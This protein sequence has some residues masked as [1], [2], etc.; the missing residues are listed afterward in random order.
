MA[1]TAKWVRSSAGDAVTVLKSV[2]QD[3]ALA[4]MEFLTNNFWGYRYV[5]TRLGQG[6]IH[7]RFRRGF[8]M[9]E[10]PGRSRFAQR[11]E[12]SRRD[13]DHRLERRDLDDRVGHSS[14]E[15]RHRRSQFQCG[16]AALSWGRYLPRKHLQLLVQVERNRL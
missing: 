12:N 11:R 7:S 8:P 2:H 6:Q 15:R 5:A 1:L 9:F 14:E 3:A 13:L 4:M 16:R 10:Y